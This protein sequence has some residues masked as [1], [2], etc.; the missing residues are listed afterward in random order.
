MRIKN[1][2][3]FEGLQGSIVVAGEKGLDKQVKSISVLEVAETRIKTWVLEDQV[4]ITSFY[5]IMKDPVAQLKVIESLN[6][7]KSSGLIICHLSIFMKEIDS[8]IIEYCNK[9]DFPLIVADSNTSYVEILNPILLRLMEEQGENETIQEKVIQLLAAHSDPQVV[10]KMLANYYG[11]MIFIL[12]LNEELVFPSNDAEAQRKINLQITSVKKVSVKPYLEPIPFEFE[13]IS[14][15]Y[16]VIQH[17][18]LIYGYIIAEIDC[19]NIQ[20]S[21]KLIR[22]ISMIYILTATNSSRKSELE[23]MKKQEF[24]NDLITWNFRSSD[25][26]INQGQR[27]GW[28]IREKKTILIINLNEYFEYKKNVPDYDKLV[29]EVLYNKVKKI[30]RNHDEELED[31]QEKQ[32]SIQRNELIKAVEKSGKTYA[33]IMAFLGSID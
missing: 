30:I 5:A 20:G 22:K 33:E 6:E 9:N 27:I 28:D 31:L 14:Y 2:M 12:N 8:R 10:Y 24:I 19:N 15:I 3:D 1:L 17:Q 7:A 4:Y 32:R 11:K 18:G 25:V 16:Y 23:I 13:G 21:V 29:N 26:A